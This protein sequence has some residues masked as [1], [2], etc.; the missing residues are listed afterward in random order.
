MSI[1]NSRSLLSILFNQDRLS[2][3]YAIRCKTRGEASYI[4][5]RGLPT[6]PNTL[7]KPYLKPLIK[8]SSK[9]RSFVARHSPTITLRGLKTYTAPSGNY[10]LVLTYANMKLLLN[11]RNLNTKRTAIHKKKKKNR[12]LVLTPILLRSLIKSRHIS[13]SIFR[14]S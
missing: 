2:G 4:T 6:Y 8:E 7:T 1:R 13:V 12:L 10:F 3:F 14:K 5:A 11:K 9:W